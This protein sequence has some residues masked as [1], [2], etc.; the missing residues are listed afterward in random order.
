VARPARVGGLR[1][2]ARPSLTRHKLPELELRAGA[3][4]HPGRRDLATK[5]TYSQRDKRER[6]R[7]LS[8][9]AELAYRRE[10]RASAAHPL[11]GWSG[12]VVRRTGDGFL[13][14]V[15]ADERAPTSGA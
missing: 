12:E 3:Q 4:R 9:Q 5:N 7:E 13:A 11:H 2:F 10:L 15:E 1:A 14:P 8:V 6:E